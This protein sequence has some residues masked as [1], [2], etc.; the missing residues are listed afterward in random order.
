MYI[1]RRFER[2]SPFFSPPIMFEVM[3]SSAEDSSV[4]GASVS[5]STEY[6]GFPNAQEVDKVSL[7]HRE[8]ER[9]EPYVFRLGDPESFVTV[10]NVEDVV[11]NQ[12]GG[13]TVERRTRVWDG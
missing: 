11:D 13:D 10:V 5:V 6:T 1:A 3:P 8:E 12:V 2:I 7:G 9:A 4:D